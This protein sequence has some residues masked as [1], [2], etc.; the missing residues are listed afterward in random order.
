MTTKENYHALMHKIKAAKSA[1]DLHRVEQSAGRLYSA[2]CLSAK[3]YG[4]I[5]GDILERM[6]SIELSKD[7]SEGVDNGKD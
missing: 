1:A 4:I 3:E 7:N 2:G 6:V 5:E